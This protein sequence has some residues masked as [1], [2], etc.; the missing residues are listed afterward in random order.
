MREQTVRSRWRW[1]LLCFLAVFVST[2]V[3][4]YMKS[5]PRGKALYARPG[6][7]L[8]DAVDWIA[9]RFPSGPPPRDS[10]E[11]A[12]AEKAAGSSSVPSP[13][14]ERRPPEEDA[15]APMEEGPP[16]SPLAERIRRALGLKSQSR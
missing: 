1:G 8:M 11:P 10:S 4:D 2:Y 16:P 3:H 9:E 7:L 12:P 5:S 14:N 15:P 13:L 6:D